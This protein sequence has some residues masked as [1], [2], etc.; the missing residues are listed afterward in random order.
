MNKKLDKQ[1]FMQESMKVTAEN[2]DKHWKEVME[3]AQKYGFITTAAGGTAVLITHKNQL[4]E[5]GQY[6]YMRI[7]RMNGNCPRL[8][9]L[10][11]INKDTLQP[12]CDSR[13][14]LRTLGKVIFSEELEKKYQKIYDIIYASDSMLVLEY[15]NWKCPKEES[16]LYIV[17]E[18]IRL[19]MRIVI[20]EYPADF[21]D[22]D[23]IGLHIETTE[24]DEHGLPNGKRQ[25]QKFDDAETLAKVLGKLLAQ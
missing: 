24:L 17:L 12:Y 22:K 1:S 25:L 18:N 21:F 23:L 2:T 16:P 8:M 20:H 3:L 10:S 19:N 4:E 14:E 13:C 5:Y 11:C 15:S 6:E 7:Q 9:G